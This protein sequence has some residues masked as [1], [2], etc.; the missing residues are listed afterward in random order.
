M[1]AVSLRVDGVQYSDDVEPRLLLVQY[2][3][4]RLGK[5]GTVIGCDTSNC[6]A[7]TVHLDG[8]SVKSCSVL[9]VQADGSEVTTIEGLGAPGEL[10]PV[11]QAFHEKHALQCG[12]CT[13]GMIMQATCLLR[14]NPNPSPAEIREGLEGN[15]CRCT[16][17]QNIVAA[18]GDAAQ[19]MNAAAIADVPDP[20][21]AQA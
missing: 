6:G 14:E 13:P 18:V 16:G 21:G 8:T 17:Y 15:L 1:T 10:H 20:A 11:Q 2:L 7:C 19:R 3:R 5:V 12:Y 9:T 4:E